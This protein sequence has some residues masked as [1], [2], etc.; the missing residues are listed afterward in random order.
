MQVILVVAVALLALAWLAEIEAGAIGAMR[1]GMQIGHDR[2]RVGAIHDRPIGM[3]RSC[4]VERALVAA[5]NLKRTDASLRQHIEMLD[6]AQVVR[7][8]SSMG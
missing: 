8:S 1:N 5:F 4:H 7:T 3:H 2:G 6:H